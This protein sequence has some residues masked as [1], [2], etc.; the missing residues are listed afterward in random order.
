MKT[1]AEI[2]T[3]LEATGKILPIN[4]TWHTGLIAPDNRIFPIRKDNQS[5]HHQKVLG[6]LGLNAVELLSKENFVR[7]NLGTYEF[8]YGND[9]AR[10]L[11]E[12]DIQ[13]S[14]F[15]PKDT[16]YIVSKQ[17]KGEF[18]YTLTYQEFLDNGN[19]IIDRPITYFS[20]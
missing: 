17:L 20:A 16:I 18:S 6:D 11:I 2:I 10:N 4:E 15:D 19:K 5:E 13:R 1:P 3:D 7:K 12:V 14:N 9:L 8:Y